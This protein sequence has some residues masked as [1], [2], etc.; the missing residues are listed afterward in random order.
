MKIA[1]KRNR[2]L[3]SEKDPFQVETGPDSSDPSKENTINKQANS[4]TE[5]SQLEKLARAFMVFIE[6]FNLDKPPTKAHLAKMQK[7]EKRRQ[8]LE[9]KKLKGRHRIH[10]FSPPHEPHDPPSSI[11]IETD[12][13]AHYGHEVHRYEPYTEP[14]YS[15]W[16]VPKLIQHLQY[17]YDNRLLTDDQIQSIN[18]WMMRCA[19]E[20][21]IPP[22]VPTPQ[23]IE[24]LLDN[25]VYMSNC[26]HIKICYFIWDRQNHGATDPT[27]LGRKYKELYL[28]V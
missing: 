12:D 21:E 24:Q 6:D 27:E 17:C 13:R 8:A 10:R 4:L 14:N 3:K 9:K 2:R 25:E 20:A 26:M 16:N 5:M 15:T 28:T 7:I 18:E 23:P 1:Q 22:E 19:Q 11:K